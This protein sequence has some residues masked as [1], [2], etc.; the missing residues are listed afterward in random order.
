MSCIKNGSGKVIVKWY[1]GN[2]S[3]P[4]ILNADRCNNIF[5]TEEELYEWQ[6]KSCETECPNCGV[7]LT[8]M[9]DEPEVI[10]YEKSLSKEYN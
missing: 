10:S 3:E 8:Q 6:A 5:K 2:D 7:N 9:Y 4:D 1:C